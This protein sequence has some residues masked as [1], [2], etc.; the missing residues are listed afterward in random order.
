MFNLFKKK[1]EAEILQEK[2]A[3]V[4]K[5]AFELS[6]VNRTKSDAKYVEAEQIMNKI[7]QIKDS[8]N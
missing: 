2:Y 1:S 4:I 3:K 6:K 7:E 8:Q 5:E